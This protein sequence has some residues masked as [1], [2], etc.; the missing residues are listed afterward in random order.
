MNRISHPSFLLRAGFLML[1]LLLLSAC[2]SDV[3]NRYYGAV[4]YPPKRA[5]EV[6]V[7][8]EN[9][10]RPYTVIADFQSRGETVA[11][12]QK[13]AAKI[14]ADAVIV[15]ALGGAYSLKEQWAGA[16]RYNQYKYNQ[17]YSRISA[18]AIKYNQ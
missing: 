6:E 16:D 5:E 15:T 13:K 10:A 12:M 17:R 8:V 2:A 4:K 1:A 3:A 9:P 11:A 18:T 14:G 7:L